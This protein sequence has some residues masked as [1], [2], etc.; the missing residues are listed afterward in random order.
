MSQD[1]LTDCRPSE[2]VEKFRNLFGTDHESLARNLGL[3]PADIGP[4]YDDTLKKLS[5]CGTVQQLADWS[6]EYRGNLSM[7]RIFSYLFLP[8][9]ERRQTLEVMSS[10]LNGVGRCVAASSL[11]YLLQPL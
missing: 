10:L 7:T 11:T 2:L 5:D 9:S 1:Q 3:E 4:G 8:G 6:L